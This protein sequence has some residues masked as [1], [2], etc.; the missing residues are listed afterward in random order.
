MLAVET[1]T[2]QLSQLAQQPGAG[3]DADR[4]LASLRDWRDGHAGTFT[5]QVGAQLGDAVRRH[6]ASVRD[7]L[8][9]LAEAARA[10]EL[11]ADLQ[12]TQRRLA[13]VIRV[14]LG[15]LIVVLGVDVFLGVKAV[16]EPHTAV[17][18]GIGAVVVWFAGTATAFTV[19]QRNL[20]AVLHRRR[21]AAS[22]AEVNQRNL[23]IALGDLRRTSQAYGEFLEWARVIAV[24]LAQPFGK[25]ATDVRPALV[26]GDGMPRSVRVGVA[27]PDESQL[28]DVVEQLR[29][30][31]YQFGWLEPI[32]EEVLSDAPSPARSRGS[33]APR[34]PEP[35]V[36]PAARGRPPA[37]PLGRPARDG[38]DRRS[39]R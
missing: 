14:L 10:D 3:A 23:A 21:Q 2:H 33:R 38:G 19:Q 6:T 25:A 13:I 28:A 31:R 30:E 12:R 16:I 36:Q 17:A 20:F 34:R 7:L 5:V 4:T 9:R 27:R 35:D 8:A 15:L 39:G 24:V 37:H 22:D 1:A 26:I 18:V 11:D 29:T 32:W